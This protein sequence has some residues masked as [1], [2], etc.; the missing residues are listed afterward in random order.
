MRGR[1][2]DVDSVIPNLALMQIS[3]WH[4]QHGDTVR[5]KIKTP[6]IVYISCVFTRNRNKALFAA[7]GDAEDKARL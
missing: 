5:W 1:L 3:A 7:R 4:K 2:V 6:D